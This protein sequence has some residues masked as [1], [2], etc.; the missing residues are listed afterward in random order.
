MLHLSRKHF[1]LRRVQT[2]FEVKKSPAAILLHAIMLVLYTVWTIHHRMVH[3][4]FQRPSKGPEVVLLVGEFLVPIV[5]LVFLL[6][7][8]MPS[9]RSVDDV[10]LEVSASS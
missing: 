3:G 6:V 4:F 7:I 2:F 8:L 9:A 10:R 5:W 1:A